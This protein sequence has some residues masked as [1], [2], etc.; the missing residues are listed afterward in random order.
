MEEL[1]F[2]FDKGHSKS[3]QA[4]TSNNKTQ[5]AKNEDHNEEYETNVRHNGKT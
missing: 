2:W 5:T 1:I 4:I 3:E